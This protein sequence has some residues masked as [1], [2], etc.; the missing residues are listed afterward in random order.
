MAETLEVR[1]GLNS[2]RNRQL[3]RIVC[4]II[5]SRARKD[6]DLYDDEGWQG[7]YNDYDDDY[8]DYNRHDDY[9]DYDD[10]K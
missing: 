4:R 5:P 6:S 7:D 8:D 10:S 3:K 9:D 1:T 2:V